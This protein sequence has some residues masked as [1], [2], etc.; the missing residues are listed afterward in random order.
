MILLVSGAT[1]TL[2]RLAG[3][4]N[5]GHLVTPDNGNSLLSLLGMG[6]P[7]GGDNS[8]LAGFSKPRYARMCVALATHIRAS[9]RTGPATARRLKY[10]TAPDAAYA[11]PDGGVLVD[12]PLT[13]RLFAAWAP[14][15]R[16]QGLPV[17]LVAQDGLTPEQTPWADMDA[18]FIGGS[19]EW[20]VGPEARALCHEARER[21][22]WV[23]V[24]R[25]N[26][27]IREHLIRDMGAHSFDGG[28]YS[29]FP[30]THIPPCLERLSRPLQQLM[31]PV[32]RQE[33]A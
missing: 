19:T 17:A 33:A 4:P 12:C 5:L 20:K 6:M 23:H 13:L 15:L 9:D 28:Q 10:V 27:E 14:W 2:Q 25:V 8:C 16:R 32:Q 26:S 11:L 1:K 24:G 21:G 29:M 18:L 31:L 22:L 7:L 30:E 3:H